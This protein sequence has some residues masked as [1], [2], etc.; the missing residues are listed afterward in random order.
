MQQ[1]EVSSMMDSY[2]ECLIQKEE[3]EKKIEAMRTTISG[4]LKDSHKREAEIVSGK[5]MHWSIKTI[6]S[7]RESFDKPMLKS[8]LSAAEYARCLKISK[9][10]QLRITQKL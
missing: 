3:L 4:F 6:E 10:V 9:Y 5:G 8:I 2:Y 1:A 7:S